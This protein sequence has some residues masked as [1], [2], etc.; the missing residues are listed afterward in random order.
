M[1]RGVDAVLARALCVKRSLSK[2]W[3]WEMSKNGGR[4]RRQPENVPISLREHKT[5]NFNWW[6]S[7]SGLFFVIP[8]RLSSIRAVVLAFTVNKQTNSQLARLHL[9]HVMAI[10][11]SSFTTL[12][13]LL[14]LMSQLQFHSRLFFSSTTLHSYYQKQ[15]LYV[16]LDDSCNL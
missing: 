13:I 6:S 14:S 8:E 15:S 1:W 5:G 3:K 9:L 10:F 7:L 16:E 4:P 11:V 2:N 12:T